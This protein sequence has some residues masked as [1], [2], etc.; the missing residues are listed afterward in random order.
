MSHICHKCGLEFK[1]NYLLLK[2]NQTKPNCEEYFKSYKINEFSCDLCNKIF[3]KKFNLERH[4]QTCL[5]KSQSN[6]NDNNIQPSTIEINEN[7]PITTTT[8]N[9]D[10]PITTTNSNNPITNTDDNDITNGNHNNLANFNNSNHNTTTNNANTTNNTTNHFNIYPFGSENI[11]FL[12]MQEIIDMLKSPN[13]AELVLEKIYSHDDNNNFS[14]MNK[15]E[16]FIY[17]LHSFDSIKCCDV[18]TFEKK[19]YDQCKTLHQRLFYKCYTNLSTEDRL[20]LFNNMKYI[21][22]I[23]D[24]RLYS[25]AGVNGTIQTVIHQNSGDSYKKEQFRKMKDNIQ[26]HK[27]EDIAHI[28]TIYNKI[29]E[30]KQQM[31]RDFNNKTLSI[32]DLKDKFWKPE[33]NNPNMDIEDDENNLYLKRLS[34]TPRYLLRKSI[35]RME[36][37]YLLSKNLSVGDLE[38]YYKYK[39]NRI[40]AEI[41]LLTEHF[42]QLQDTYIKEITD[43]LLE[44]PSDALLENIRLRH[45]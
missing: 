8:T 20:I 9:S 18:E 34:E 16:D 31:T 43:L 11:N 3:A 41:T 36:Y 23:L 2:H 37:Q 28:K 12:S 39:Q 21:A 35:E 7:N 19:M 17:Y 24:K 4:Y 38:L 6:N 44:C 27:P 1:Y 25:H 45:S 32:K 33:M 30:E 13:C 10:N 40:N 29:Q 15:K 14:R 26:H 22:D 5:K 42:D